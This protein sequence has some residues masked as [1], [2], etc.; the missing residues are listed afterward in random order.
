[1][2]HISVTVG[3]NM[4]QRQK[5]TSPYTLK[6]HY[7]LNLVLKYCHC[8]ATGLCFVYLAIL[9]VLYCICICLYAN[10]P[11]WLY[12]LIK[13]QVS[14]IFFPLREAPMRTEKNTFKNGH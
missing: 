1:M 13:Y 6:F 9:I 8:I 11:L 14:S 4:F 12:A 10:G 7:D 3:K 2:R 5:S